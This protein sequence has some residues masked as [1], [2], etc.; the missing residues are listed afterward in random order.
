MAC[1]TPSAR[2]SRYPIPKSES[3]TFLIPVMTSLQVIFFCLNIF[4]RKHIDH[5]A[6]S[7]G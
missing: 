4:L 2:M 1:S 6:A 3:M 5:A 7:E